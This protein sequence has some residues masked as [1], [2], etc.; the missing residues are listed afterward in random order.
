MCVYVCSDTSSTSETNII[1]IFKWPDNMSDHSYS[2]SDMVLLDLELGTCFLKFLL[3]SAPIPQHKV[4]YICLL[5]YTYYAFIL[6]YCA[7]QYTS[8]TCFIRKLALY[9]SFCYTFLCSGQTLKYAHS[10]S[11]NVAK[12]SCTHEYCT[13]GTGTAVDYLIASCLRLWV[14]VQ[15]K[16][17]QQ[18]N[19]VVYISPRVHVS[20][21]LARA[22]YS[23]R[24]AIA[25]I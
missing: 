1:I 19:E 10:S 20:H 15:L 6:Q 17:S 21:K 13:A 24:N 4:N 2:W 22:K 18:K 25:T 9:G 16:Y 12:A 7:G 3:R 8:Q 11:L 14:R 23:Y 5:F